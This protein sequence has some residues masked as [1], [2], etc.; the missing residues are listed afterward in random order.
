MKRGVIIND[1]N[2]LTIQDFFDP[3]HRG[4]LTIDE[5]KKKCQRSSK[6]HCNI[7]TETKGRSE[8]IP[9]SELSQWMEETASLLEL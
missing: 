5:H 3:A 8:D 7:T 9:H 6:A 2:W 4:G 1:L